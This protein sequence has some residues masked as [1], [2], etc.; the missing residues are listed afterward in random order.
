MPS[1]GDDSSSA[2]SARSS[3]KRK[4]SGEVVPVSSR[5][6]AKLPKLLQALS[7]ALVY[8]SQSSKVVGDTTDRGSNSV[9]SAEYMKTVLTTTAEESGKILGSW[10]SLS[11][12]IIT[13]I[14]GT[15][16]E[17]GNAWFSPFIDIW[18]LHTAGNDELVQ[19]SSILLAAI[20]VVATICKRY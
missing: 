18:E 12:D 5:E 7:S 10:L 19:F 4:R 1:S 8:I 20:I 9:F 6:R 14:R 11:Q 2:S 13:H 17:A 15:E 16:T 3:R